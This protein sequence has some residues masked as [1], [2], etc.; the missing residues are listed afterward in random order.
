MDK[1]FSSF[2]QLL[3]ISMLS[4]V[5]LS[6]SPQSGKEG[7]LVWVVKRLSQFSGAWVK[8]LYNILAC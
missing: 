6:T 5:D 3:W 8:Y 7:K 4:L 2:A 1:F